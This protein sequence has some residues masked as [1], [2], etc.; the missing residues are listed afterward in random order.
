M[1]QRVKAYIKKY[2]MLEKQDRIV[3][4]VSGGPDSICLLFMLKE[5]RKEMD[6]EVLAIHVNHGRISECG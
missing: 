6:L 3:T 5:L 4:G 1:Y 2:H